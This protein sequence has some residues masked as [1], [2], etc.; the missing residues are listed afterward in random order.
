MKNYKLVAIL[1]LACAITSCKTTA[2]LTETFESD[3]V[4][5]LPIKDIPGD[6]VGDE[7]IYET[8]LNPRL[9]ITTSANNAG[10]KA[11]TF[12]QA[13]ATGLDL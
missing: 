2:V 11:L 6:P 4:G 5:S 7:V 10:E 12:S 13:P 3:V 1:L 8:V 9:R